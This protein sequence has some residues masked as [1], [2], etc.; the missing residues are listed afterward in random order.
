MRN[1]PIRLFLRFSVVLTSG[2]L[3]VG[4]PVGILAGTPSVETIVAV[5]ANFSA[6]ARELAGM[7]REETGLQVVLVFGSTGKHHAQ[8]KNGAP[9]AAFLAAD[10]RR[11][12]LLVAEGLAV[13]ESRFTYATGRLVLWSP[14]ADLVDDR[15]AILGR[16][17]FRYLALANPDLAPYGRAAMEVLGNRDL[18]AA[19]QSR[20]VRGEN[21]S[22]VFQYVASGSADLGFVALSQF[23][24]LGPG[25]QGSWWL[26]P[27]ELHEP[28]RQQ[29]VLL[30]ED[31]VAR[32]FLEF[33][34]SARARHVILRYG[35]DVEE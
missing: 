32:A 35:Y 21:I 17:G 6:P 12:R 2:L 13:P 11:P 1:L 30:R 5:S 23:R 33:L 19:V 27:A 15:G 14:H 26:V 7:F 31:P 24:C 18:L 28:I 8:I 4:L 20:I 9:F 29:A 34:K 16:D 22:Q 10:I 25:E 3:G